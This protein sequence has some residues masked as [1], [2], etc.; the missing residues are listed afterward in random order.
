LVVCIVNRGWALLAS[1][2]VARPAGASHDRLPLG[3]RTRGRK[4]GHGERTARHA[5]NQQPRLGV[6]LRKRAQIRREQFPS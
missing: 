5:V 4:R 6:V 2:P 1:K 3:R